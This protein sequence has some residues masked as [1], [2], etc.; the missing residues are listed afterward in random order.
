MSNPRYQ[1]ITARFLS[2]V[3]GKDPDDVSNSEDDEKEGDG[4]SL[5]TM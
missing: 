1:N 5:V 2:S 4:L 3:R